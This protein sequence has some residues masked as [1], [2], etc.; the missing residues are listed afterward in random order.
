MTT[1]MREKSKTPIA[2]ALSMLLVLFAIVE[3]CSMMMPAEA[4]ASEMAHLTSGGRINYAGY[5][6]TWFDVDGEV[7]YC[8]NPSASTPESGLYEKREISATSGRNQ[9]TVADLWFGYGSPGFDKSLWPATWYD[10]SPMTDER[11]AALAHIL[12]SDTF[13][14]NGHYALFGTDETFASWCRQNVIGY[15]TSGELINNDAT[16]LK[17]SLRIGAVCPLPGV[18]GENVDTDIACAVYGQ[19]IVGFRRRPAHAHQEDRLP[20][21]FCLG[22]DVLVEALFLGVPG[23]PIAGE[24]RLGGNGAAGVFQPLLHRDSVADVYIARAGAEKLRSSSNC[25]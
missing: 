23:C 16:G 2:K 21:G 14:S 6:T 25:S 3:C 5:Y 17:I 24:P 22:G 15:G 20:L 19:I 9:E 12:L 13:S 7:A 10:G 11:Y 8:G 18:A 4:H 1:A